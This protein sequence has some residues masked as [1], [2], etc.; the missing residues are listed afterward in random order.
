MKCIKVKVPEAHVGSDKCIEGAPNISRVG[1]EFTL[2]RVREGHFSK[3]LVVNISGA[4]VTLKHG[5]NI[6]QCIMYDK[7][8]V[9]EPEEFSAAYV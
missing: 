4:P 6:S 1:V 2:S 7:Q 9:T 5:L 8:V 3:A